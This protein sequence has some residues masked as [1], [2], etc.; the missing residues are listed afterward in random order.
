MRVLSMMLCLGL[1]SAC[2]KGSSGGA[3]APA[4]DKAAKAMLREFLKPGVDLVALSMKLKPTSTDYR[5]VF[6]TEEMAK[7]AEETYSKLWEMV[8]KRPLGPKSGQTELLLWSATTDELKSGAGNAK[9]FPGGY[10]RAAPHLKG[11]LKVFRFKFVEPGKTLGMSFDGLYNL[12]GRWV[13]MPKPWRI[14][15]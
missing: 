5:A 12:G 7:K 9:E 3:A 6:A 2:N 11:G 4:T 14:T 15:R 1:L 13:L 8:A 10:T